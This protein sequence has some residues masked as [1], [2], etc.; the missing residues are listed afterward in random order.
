[1]SDLYDIAE[2]LILGLSSLP[3]LLDDPQ[4]WHAAAQEACAALSREEAVEVM[5]IV[6]STFKTG[7]EDLAAASRGLE[8][9]EARLRDRVALRNEL[10]AL[11][12]TDEI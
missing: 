10:A 9:F 12:A 2:E 4:A 3:N 1:M 8:G 7:W 6:A 5:V 11:E